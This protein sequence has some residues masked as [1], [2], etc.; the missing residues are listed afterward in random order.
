MDAIADPEG[1]PGEDERD[2]AGCR[3]AQEMRRQQRVRELNLPINAGKPWTAGEDAA[4]QALL[5]HGLRPSDIAR[6]FGRSRDAVA[7]RL[8][9]LGLMIEEVRED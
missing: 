5:R 1:D 9:R 2:R 7:A 3:Q 4:L 6:R 8:I